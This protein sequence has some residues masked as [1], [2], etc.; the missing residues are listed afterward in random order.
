[1]P[2]GERN[3]IETEEVP[4]SFTVD[5]SEHFAEEIA[6]S[7]RANG[8]QLKDVVSVALQLFLKVDEA[9]RSGGTVEVKTP[10]RD[11]LTFTLKPYEGKV[12]G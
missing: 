5:V 2:V 4:R 3:R 1:M 9:R 7:A 10:R 8:F 6:E 12:D 11:D